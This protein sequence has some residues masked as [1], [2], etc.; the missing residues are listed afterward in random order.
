MCLLYLLRAFEAYCII[1]FGSEVVPAQFQRGLG[2]DYCIFV[3][4]TIDRLMDA[5]T[6]THGVLKTGT[7]LFPI[8]FITRN[9]NHSNTVRTPGNG[10]W[11]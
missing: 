3:V 1:C 9:G 6:T 5:Q 11:A 7:K 8:D 2:L 10:G 4:I